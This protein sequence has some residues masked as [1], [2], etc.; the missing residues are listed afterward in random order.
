MLP[1][2]AAGLANGRAPQVALKGLQAVGYLEQT[3]ADLVAAAL[4]KVGVD[5]PKLPL[6]DA[7]SSALLALAL[8]LRAANPKVRPPP[9]CPPRVLAASRRA[10]PPAVAVTRGDC[11]GQAGRVCCAV[12]VC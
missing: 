10:E 12:P 1:A 8:E 11:Q 9:H 7:T 4:T 6:L 5:K 2:S 3:V